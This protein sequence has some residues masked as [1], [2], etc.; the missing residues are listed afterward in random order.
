MLTRL[1][2]FLD[3]RCSNCLK[4]MGCSAMSVSSYFCRGD[5]QVFRWTIPSTSTPSDEQGLERLARYVIRSPVSLQRLHCLPQTKQVFYQ[6]NKGHDQDDSEI[7]DS[8]EFVARVLLHVLDLNKP[9]IH[10]YGIYSNRSQRKPHKVSTSAE[11]TPP[12]VSNSKLRRRWTD[13]IR[14]VYQTDPLICP[15]AVQKCASS[16]SLPN[17]G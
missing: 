2:S 6:A 17:P 8:I 7:V 5:I 14:R 12:P 11:A 1:S 4:T 3:T 9:Y 16:P 10:Y 13:L 15:N